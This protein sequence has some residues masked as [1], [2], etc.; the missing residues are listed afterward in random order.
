MGQLL[1]IMLASLIIG[2]N[3]IIILSLSVLFLFSM[4]C[5]IYCTKQKNGN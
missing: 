2:P 3:V 1:T 5:S 4:L